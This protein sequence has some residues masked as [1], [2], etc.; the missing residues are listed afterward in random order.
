MENHKELK[1]NWR[2]TNYMLWFPNELLKVLKSEIKDGDR[3]ALTIIDATKVKE[4]NGEDNYEP[5]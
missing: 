2:G 5:E 1:I 3:L 4:I